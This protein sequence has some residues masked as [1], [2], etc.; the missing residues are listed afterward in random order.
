MAL[1]KSQNRVGQISIHEIMKINKLN[2]KDYAAQ[3]PVFVAPSG[4]FSTLKEV[5]TD[6]KSTLGSLHTLS[7]EQQVKLTLERY[8]MEPD[9]QLGIFG[10]GTMTKAEIMKEI[11][12]QTAFGV[13]AVQVEMQYC[14]ELMLDVR[15]T[16]IPKIPII[17]RKPIRVEPYWKYF[18]KCLWLRLKNTALFAENTT[19]G[20]TTPFANY[21]IAHVHTKFAARGF[22]VVANTGTADTRT[23][24]MTTAKKSLTTYIGGIGHGNYNRYTGHAGENILKV[25]E[26]D[27]SEVKGKAIH[28][29]SCRTAATLG[30][31]T[32]TKGAKCYAGYDENFTFVWDNSSTPVNE[33]DLFK[34][35]DSTFDLWMAH[36]YS[37]QQA[38]NA[39]IATFNA[40]IAQV[41]GTTAAS[42]L[43]Y[44]RDH[45]RLHGDPATKV[46]PYR[47]V[48]IC[49]PFRLQKHEEMLAEIGELVD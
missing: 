35:S 30:P 10:Q 47:Y 49:F 17:P 8:K 44:D 15:K 22:N 18:R 26:Y 33:V 24:F 23:N 36:G 38:Y 29:L 41:P 3:K 14:N 48:R 6:R 4:K 34:K 16:S 25:G 42:W 19:D 20:V 40:C 31:D 27:A 5:I 21:R 43:S 32:I 7:D 9:F 37:A 11:Q 2:F 46:S 39:T 1:P 13:L 12:A 28:F 45:L